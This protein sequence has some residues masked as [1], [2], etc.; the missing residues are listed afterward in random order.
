M[1]IPTNP[2]PFQS[3]LPVW[4]A[5]A[6]YIRCSQAAGF[7]STLPVWGATSALRPV[8]REQV[9]FQSTLPVWGATEKQTHQQFRQGNFN[10]RSPCGE[11]QQKYPKIFLKKYII[12]YIAQNPKCLLL[13]IAP[14]L[15]YFPV[16]SQKSGANLPE[17]PWAL[18]LRT[19]IK[20]WV[21]PGDRCF[22]SRNAQFFSHTDFPDNKTAGC[23]F[24]GP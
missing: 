24:P 22:Y 11:R 19:L 9:E 10:P 15:K 2:S 16:F 23:P 18:S 17:K 7:Q 20:S 3:T 6:A 5:T 8:S 12:L 1:L 14:L 4:G 13:L 21:P